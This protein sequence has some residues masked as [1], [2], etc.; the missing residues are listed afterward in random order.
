HC[1]SK[2]R[3]SV[4]CAQFSYWMYMQEKGLC[5]ETSSVSEKFSR[6]V[7][8]CR[9]DVCAEFSPREA[10]QDQGRILTAEAEA[11][12]HGNVHDPFARSVGDVVKVAVIVWLV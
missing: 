5:Q 11:V 2:G 8:Q 7:P 6:T 3:P 10:S 1:T 12:G 4:C 9:G